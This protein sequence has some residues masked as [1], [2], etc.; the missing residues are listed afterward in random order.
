MELDFNP[1]KGDD[2]KISE[3]TETCKNN[4][5]DYTLPEC[6]CATN[7]VFLSVSNG[8]KMF[9]FDIKT[10]KRFSETLDIPYTQGGYDYI[11]NTFWFYKSD[12]ATP[13]LKSFK[14]DGFKSKA[15]L[16]DSTNKNFNEFAKKRTSK[17]IEEQKSDHRIAT[18]TLE[19]F[20]KKLGN[21]RVENFIPE[22]KQNH[23][24]HQSLFMIMYAIGKG[25]EQ[26]DVVMSEF[27]S[28]YPDLIEERLACQTKLFR[29]E[30]ASSVS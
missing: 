1:E 9:F 28:L 16:S 22:S 26:M 17:T 30:Y 20:L 11:D 15:E 18:R 19:G 6:I 10:G 23:D 13:V 29:S 14:V 3:E 27:D 4:F 12:S 8:G 5:S 2:Q 7:G 25:C 24:I 21:K